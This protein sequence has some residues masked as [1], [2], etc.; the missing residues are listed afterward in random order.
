MGSRSLR[1]LLAIVSF[2]VPTEGSVAE[3]LKFTASG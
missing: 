1:N 2:H 3:D